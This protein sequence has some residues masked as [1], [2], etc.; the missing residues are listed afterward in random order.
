VHELCY[1][2]E[3]HDDV[4]ARERGGVDMLG[5]TRTPGLWLVVGLGVLMLGVVPILSG[6]ARGAVITVGAV[7]ALAAVARINARRAGGHGEPPLPPP[8]WSGPGPI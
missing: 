7:V 2:C 3:A 5:R 6:G 1:A 4:V 8:G